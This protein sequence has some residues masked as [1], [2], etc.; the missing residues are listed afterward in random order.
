VFSFLLKEMNA[1]IMFLLI[2]EVL[3]FFKFLNKRFDNPVTGGEKE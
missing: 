1:S 3:C 2:E